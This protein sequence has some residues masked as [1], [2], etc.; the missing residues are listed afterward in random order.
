MRAF[1]PAPSRLATL[2]M[3][4]GLLLAVWCAFRGSLQ[5]PFFFDDQTAITLNPSIRSLARLDRVLLPPADG[6][7]M[8][9][10]PL[11]NLTLAIDYALGGLEP[12]GYHLTNLALHGCAA[13]ALAGLVRR[14][15]ELPALRRRYGANAQLLAFACAL[16]WSVHPLQTESVSCVIQRTEVLVSLFY[17]LTLYAFVRG[18]GEADQSRPGRTA[19]PPSESGPPRALRSGW[20]STRWPAIAIGAS[21]LGM[22]SKEV[23]V[24]APLVVLLYDRTFVSG[25]F[26]AAWQ[27]HRAWHLGLA[28]TWLVLLG[29]LW[30]MGGNRGVA[31][32]FGLGV[33]P[34]AYAWTQAGAIATYLKLSFW[35]HPLVI[36]YGTTLVSGPGAVIPQLL[37]VTTL[38]VATFVALRLRPA[39]GF[40][41]FTFF[42]LLAP[43][44]SIVPLVTQTVA[45]HRMYLPLAALVTGFV[46]LSHRLPGRTAATAAALAA[47]G[48][49]GITTARN[50]VLQD[51]VALW[52]DTAAKVPANAR[53]HASLGLA[54]SD[55]GRPAEAVPHF[56]RA[57]ALDPKSV[58]TE[59][60]LGNAWFALRNFRE[61]ADH[62]RRAIA[63]NPNFAS[64]HNNLGATLL[65]L[66]DTGGALASYRAAL[67]LD[68]RHAGARQ[69]LGRTLLGLGRLADA[70]E[71]Y[72]E[73]LRLEP[74]SADAHYQLGGALGRAGRIDEALPHF[75][76]ALELKPGAVSYLNYARFLSEAGRPTDAIAALETAL[77]LRPDFPEA[78]RELARLRAG[79]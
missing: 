37:L 57:L 5:V 36:D 55:R 4:G 18:T 50:A 66:G 35:P 2:A 19:S 63:L 38:V 20:A 30:Q 51:E 12:R 27:R 26:R 6:S 64:G 29:G 42:A 46:I 71:V 67:A 47:L 33:S 21:A 13:L 65:E 7:G 14:T 3:A 22:A 58:A 31:A 10:R 59:Q 44:S 16:L 49:G 34:W 43:S 39:I 54:L 73:R 52:A 40:L 79:R 9:G 15:L 62:F 78:T 28:A 72:A 1:R 69:N 75:V 70:I 61:A 8:T 32:G 68:P 45:E 77:R 23:M 41:A 24:S 60:N 25:T 48:L 11:V 53:A 56:Q 74:D 76:R 17:L